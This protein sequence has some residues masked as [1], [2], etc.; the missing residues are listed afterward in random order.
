M[1]LQTLKKEYKLLREDC[2]EKFV[3][4]SQVE[5]SINSV[6]EYWI[7]SDET[8]GNY[9]AYFNTYELA[10]EYA[11]DR[12]DYRMTLNADGKKPFVIFVNGKEINTMGKLKEFL[13]GAQSL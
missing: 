10:M 6:E 3:K 13:K 12:I 11:L 4:V 7:T 2:S 5:P 9:H 1:E 8:L